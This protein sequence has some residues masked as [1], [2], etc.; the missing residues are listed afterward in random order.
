MIYTLYLRGHMSVRRGFL[1]VTGV[2]S[3][4]VPGYGT[5]RAISNAVCT[6]NYSSDL[7]NSLVTEA[8]RNIFYML[9]IVFQ[10]PFVLCL[11][12]KRSISRLLIVTMSTVLAGNFTMCVNVFLSVAMEA[13]TKEKRSQN[14]TVL[15]NNLDA[16]LL[17]VDCTKENVTFVIDGRSEKHLQILISVSHRV[18]TFVLLLSCTDVEVT[19]KYTAAYHKEHLSS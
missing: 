13:K 15:L 3:L 6:K 5:Y 7:E 9:Y 18:C 11:N 8:V 16:E 2:G 1:V 19:A 10:M 14:I 12:T 4:A 17:Y